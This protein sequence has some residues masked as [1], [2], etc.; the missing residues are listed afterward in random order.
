[1]TH[2]GYCELSASLVGV[3][4]GLGHQWQAGRTKKEA[5]KKGLSAPVDGSALGALGGCE[6]KG[7]TPGTQKCFS[8]AQLMLNTLG[9]SP[10]TPE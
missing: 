1:M 2:G 6:V 3:G 8:E 5:T 4:S 9:L 10:N 7:R